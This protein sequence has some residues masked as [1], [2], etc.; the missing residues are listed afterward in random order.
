VFIGNKVIFSY[1]GEKCDTRE[2]EEIAKFTKNLLNRED[3]KGFSI[4]KAQPPFQDE[5][6]ELLI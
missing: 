6:V 2:R 1:E 4:L 5:F 3:C